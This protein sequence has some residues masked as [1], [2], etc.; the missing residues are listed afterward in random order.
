MFYYGSVSCIWVGRMGASGSASPSF[1]VGDMGS[2]GDCTKAAVVWVQ[3]QVV[4]SGAPPPNPD[5]FNPNGPQSDGSFNWGDMRV[6]PSFSVLS[7]PTSRWRWVQ[8]N[9]G[10]FATTFFPVRPVQITPSLQYPQ[11]PNVWPG[12]TGP[13]VN[14]IDGCMVPS[15]VP[16]SPAPRGYFPWVQ[17][18]AI[19]YPGIPEPPSGKNILVLMTTIG[20]PNPGFNATMPTTYGGAGFVWGYSRRM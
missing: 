8:T 20:D 4:T 15:I 2:S 9:P 19:I 18:T 14:N 7:Q 16:Y 3:L 5:P 11:L 1:A 17:G 12:T 6:V 10:Y 13:P